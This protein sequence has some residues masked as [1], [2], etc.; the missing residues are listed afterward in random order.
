MAEIRRFYKELNKFWREEIC[1]VVEA[2][3]KRRV[4]PRDFERWNGFRSSL[5]QTIE[6]WK[7]FLLPLLLDIPNQSNNMSRIGQQTVVLKPYTAITHPPLQSVY[8]PSA[9]VFP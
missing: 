6:F 7:V 5:K 4:D 8:S 2:L 9:L 1:C 3:K